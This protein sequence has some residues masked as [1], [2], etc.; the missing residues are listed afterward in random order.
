MPFELMLAFWGRLTHP[1]F[2][3]VPAFV[4]DVCANRVGVLTAD[5]RGPRE[6]RSIT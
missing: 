6:K 2:D 3:T 1:R 4:E 5:L